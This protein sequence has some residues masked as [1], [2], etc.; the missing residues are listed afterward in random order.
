MPSLASVIDCLNEAKKEN[1]MLKE[2]LG[3]FHQRV[4]LVL[5]K[6]ELIT[7]SLL[8]IIEQYVGDLPECPK[9]SFPEFN[10][11]D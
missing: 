10:E 1:I 2:Q 8:G 7:N 3:S 11:R 5:I 4:S 6:Q 9:M